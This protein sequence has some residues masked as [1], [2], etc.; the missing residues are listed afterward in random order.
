MRQLWK[1]LY[2]FENTF[3]TILNLPAGIQTAMVPI[4]Y[5]GP[6][7]MSGLR[8]NLYTAPAFLSALVGILNL[9][10]L[11][12]VFKEHR[13]IDEEYSHS[14]QDPGLSTMNRI[15]YC[16]Y[17]RFVPCWISIN[18]FLKKINAFV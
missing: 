5:P 17:L 16:V 18:Y 12:L 9:L 8:I 4:G 10:L 13:V 14:I 3:N 1:G 6:V 2:E 15:Y 7:H 11:F